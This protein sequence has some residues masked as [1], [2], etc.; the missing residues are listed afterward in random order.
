MH[1]AAA[2]LLS[3]RDKSTSSEQR[4]VRGSFARSHILPIFFFFSSLL[5]EQLSV[6]NSLKIN[7]NLQ[8]AEPC[9]CSLPWKR[10]TFFAETDAFVE[11]CKE[12]IRKLW[13]SFE[14][15]EINLGDVNKSPCDI[16]KG[17]FRNILASILWKVGAKITKGWSFLSTG[18]FTK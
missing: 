17:Y 6:I 7:K 3:N 12:K 8:T 5:V 4:W 14:S 2:G 13:D 11:P 10:G 16:T 15:V 9:V 1:N 18:T